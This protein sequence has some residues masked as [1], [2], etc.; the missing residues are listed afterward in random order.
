MFLFLSHWNSIYN[1]QNALGKKL[2]QSGNILLCLKNINIMQK[3]SWFPVKTLVLVIRKN[4]LSQKNIVLGRKEISLKRQTTVTGAIFLSHEKFLCHMKNPLTTIKL[5]WQEQLIV[6]K[7]N[8]LTSISTSC[9]CHRNHDQIILVGL[10]VKFQHTVIS[11]TCP[12]RLK[13]ILEIVWSA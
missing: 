2:L 6:M 1:D 8:L 4:F 11:T 7:T 5:C 12:V 13:R 3:H 9:T 10:F